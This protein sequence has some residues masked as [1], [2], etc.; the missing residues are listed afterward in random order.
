MKRVQLKPFSKNDWDAFAG[1]E[2]APGQPAMIW[3]GDEDVVVV[4]KGGIEVILDAT[5]SWHLDV[6]Y[7]TA[8]IV[9]ANLLVPISPSQLLDLGFRIL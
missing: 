2:E 7:A 1:A 6:S 8:L 3:Y 4:D 5:D 9:A